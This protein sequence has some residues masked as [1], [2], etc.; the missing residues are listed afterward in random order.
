MSNQSW[1][2]ALI[3]AQL[4]GGPVSN[5]TTQ[6]TLLPGQAL[7]TLQPDTTLPTAGTVMRVTLTGQ[8]SNVVTTPGT[9]TILILFGATTVYTSG[10]M[11]MS[12]TAHTTLP[13]WFEV[14]LTCR[15]VGSAANFMAQGVIH[16]QP[17]SLTA[18]TDSATTVATLMAPN[19][20]PAVGS[21]FSTKTSQQQDVQS[22]F[23][24]N[25]SGTNITLQQYLVELTN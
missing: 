12:T 11:Q 9:L 20:T 4:A 3:T 16:G 24:V 1:V 25:T 17:M 10:A 8:I 22:A 7:F 14:L 23:S 13:F 18:T 19:V 15:A 2:Q 6:T 21:N 5:T